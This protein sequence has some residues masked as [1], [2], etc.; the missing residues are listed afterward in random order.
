MT[1]GSIKRCDIHC[2]NR[3][4][5]RYDVLDQDE[6]HR[7]LIEHTVLLDAG[8]GRRVYG[9]ADHPKG[10]IMELEHEGRMWY[11]VRRLE[12]EVEVTITYLT[13]KMAADK[14]AL[15]LQRKWNGT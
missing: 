7:I 12:G 11:P 4:I 5:E 10:R 15:E 3:L 1:A 13:P 14:M 2:I 9:F 8:G 6:A